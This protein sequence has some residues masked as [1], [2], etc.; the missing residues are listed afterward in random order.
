MGHQWESYHTAESCLLS[1]RT[2]VSH[3]RDMEHPRQCNSLSFSLCF[4]PSFHPFVSPSPS[5]LSLQVLQYLSDFRV[6]HCPSLQITEHR[7]AGDD[8]GRLEGSADIRLKVIPHDA[9]WER[10]GGGRETQL[11][12]GHGRW[13]GGWVG[14]W[15]GRCPGDFR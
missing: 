7:S 6:Q 2:A 14:G 3:F 9:L 4:S 12:R 15:V 5:P 10:E 11:H 8:G 13:V 1:F